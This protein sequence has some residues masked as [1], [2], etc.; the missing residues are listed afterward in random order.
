[1]SPREALVIAEEHNLDLV[2][3]APNATP[4]V[5]KIMDYGKYR[6][7]QQMKERE[8]KKHQHIV[9]I[10][11][12]RFRPRIG[13]H[14]RLMKVNQIRKFIGDGSKVKVTVMFRG[15]EMAHKEF[16]MELL[17]KIAQEVADIGVMEKEP[18]S[19]GRIIVTHFISK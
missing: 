15:R 4:P 2:E 1:M 11:E 7:Q 6:Y 8:S 13:D 14:D 12:V 19:E 5:C 3:V 18:I 9:K 16:G 17:Q 10:K